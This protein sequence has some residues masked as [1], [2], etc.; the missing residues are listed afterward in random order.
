LQAL[1]ERHGQEIKRLK[2]GNNKIIYDLQEEIKRLKT[3]THASLQSN[4]I[5]DR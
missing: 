4:L 3:E 5:H 2:E 1:K